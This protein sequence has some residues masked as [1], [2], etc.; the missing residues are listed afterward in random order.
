MAKLGRCRRSEA[1]DDRSQS[2]WEPGRRSN[3]DVQNEGRG[4]PGHRGLPEVLEVKLAFLLLAAIPPLIAQ[5]AGDALVV[6]NDASP[7]SR[8]IAEYYVRKRSIPIANV[9]HLKV[10]AAEDISRE[11]YETSIEAPIAA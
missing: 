9:C 7:V 10:G 8:R 4:R 5:E 6:V 3:A 11:A 1:A 2:P